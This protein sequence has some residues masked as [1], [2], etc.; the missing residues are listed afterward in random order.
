M[1]KLPE[2]TIV[3]KERNPNANDKSGASE[4]LLFSGISTYRPRV[5]PG[6]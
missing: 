6:L 1:K 3:A 4:K 5:P 2:F